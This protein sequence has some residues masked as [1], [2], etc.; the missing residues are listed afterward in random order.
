[1]LNISDNIPWRFRSV[2]N[3]MTYFSYIE[4]MV[5]HK[6]F[7]FRKILKTPG[8]VCSANSHT[9]IHSL[10]CHSDVNMYL[11]AIKSFL[12]YYTNIGVVVHDD[13]SLTEND[14]DILKK[15]IINI[16]IISFNEVFQS[17]HKEFKALFPAVDS[18]IQHLARTRRQLFKLFSFVLYGNNKKI[19][20]MDSDIIFQNRPDE[21]IEWIEKDDFTAFYNV[22]LKCALGTAKETMVKEFG[23]PIIKKFNSGFIG[24]QNNIDIEEVKQYLPIY[25]NYPQIDQGDQSLFAILLSKRGAQPLNE[26]YYSVFNRQNYN[27]NSKMI[28][29]I[30]PNR[31]YNGV[32]FKLAKNV[33]KDLILTEPF[34]QRK[35]ISR[36]S[37]G[38]RGLS[39]FNE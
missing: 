9:E 38:Y 28:H 32:Y 11:I 2:D 17:F 15:H 39:T 20:S 22:D 30:Y 37:V 1:M 3:F 13:S 12:R 31:F 26:K 36:L 6:N 25:T 8:A 16:K 19:I 23:F 7:L 5:R 27:K 10:V 35:V 14:K 24:Y 4:F 34:F 21:I 18:N 33:C 29:F